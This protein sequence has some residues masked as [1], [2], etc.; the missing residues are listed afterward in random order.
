MIELIRDENGCSGVLSGAMTIYE[1]AELKRSLDE[2]WSQDELL[3][4]DLAAVNE[5]DTSGVQ[6]LL[7]LRQTVGS[8]LTLKM[9]SAA[10]IDIFDLYQLAPFFGDVIVLT[11]H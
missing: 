3:C 10:V 6:W 8:R 11:D 5:I 2:F 1:V 7:A 4:L 9:H